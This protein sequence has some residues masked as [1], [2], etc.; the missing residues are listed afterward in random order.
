MLNVP[1]FEFR[2]IALSKDEKESIKKL[3]YLKYNNNP[4][5]VNTPSV[6]NNE[7]FLELPDIIM[8]SVPI[9]IIKIRIPSKISSQIA[10]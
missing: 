10:L 1:M 7:D 5:P 3:K 2:P 4:N 6:V 9:P 8:P